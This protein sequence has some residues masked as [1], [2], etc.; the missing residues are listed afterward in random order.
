PPC[1][2]PKGFNV[3]GGCTLQT[4]RDLPSPNSTGAIP[5]AKLGEVY[6]ATRFSLISR[7]RSVSGPRLLASANL[8]LL[9]HPVSITSGPNK[10]SDG[11]RMLR[12]NLFELRRDPVQCCSF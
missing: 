4:H 8:S 2:V 5:S 10:F 7:L 6:S 11:I 12:R 1:N 3:T 9:R